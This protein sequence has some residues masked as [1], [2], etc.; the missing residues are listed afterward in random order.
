MFIY[1]LVVVIGVPG[2]GYRKMIDVKR[3]DENKYREDVLRRIMG[4][5]PKSISKVKE[6]NA[7]Q[8]SG[9]YF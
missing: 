3:W 8:K 1:V 5:P 2:F 7:E 9:I 4:D 6:Q